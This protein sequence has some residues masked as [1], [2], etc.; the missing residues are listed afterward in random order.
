MAEEQALDRMYQLCQ[1]Q[2]VIAIPYKAKDRIDEYVVAIQKS[3]LDL[4]QQSFGQNNINK[5]ERQRER[6][7][8]RSRAYAHVLLN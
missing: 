5:A 7:K 1:T 2:P 4:I 6:L 8:F 3:K